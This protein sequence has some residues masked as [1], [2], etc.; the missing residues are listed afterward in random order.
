MKVTNDELLNEVLM[1][2]QHP[3]EDSEDVIPTVR[4][5]IRVVKSFLQG[6]GA[7]EEALNSDLAI[8]VIVMGVNDIWD[9]TSGRIR[10]SPT[11]F[12]LANQLTSR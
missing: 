8:G 7:S 12:I 6:A 11:F 9:L 4:Q 3:I 10:F 5:K 1:G 2:L